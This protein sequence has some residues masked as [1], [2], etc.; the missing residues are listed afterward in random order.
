[1]PGRTRR[2]APDCVYGPIQTVTELGLN[3]HLSMGM[4]WDSRLMGFGLF[5]IRPWTASGKTRAIY[6]RG[7]SKHTV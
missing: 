2:K 7:A 1:M 6:M 3:A 4:G 5:S